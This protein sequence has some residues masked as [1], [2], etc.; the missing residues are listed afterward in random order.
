MF[1][2]RGSVLCVIVF[3]HPSLEQ[4]YKHLAKRDQ[5]SRDQHRV[6]TCCSEETSVVLLSEFKI[7]VLS[8]ALSSE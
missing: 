5:V 8:I 2:C 7:Q 4:E 3:S 6:I 1:Q